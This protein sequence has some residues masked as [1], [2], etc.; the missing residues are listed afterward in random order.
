MDDT[1]DFPA[2][3]AATGWTRPRAAE[4]LGVH[5]STVDR[6]MRPVDNPRHLLPSVEI[7]AKCRA[8]TR[9]QIERLT[10]FA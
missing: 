10:P 4:E 7:V 2:W 1:F 8:A 9:R 3:L 5:P 6:L